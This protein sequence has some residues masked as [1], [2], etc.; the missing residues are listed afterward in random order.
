MSDFNCFE[1]GFTFEFISIKFVSNT[2]KKV[3]LVVFW[4]D[5][6]NLLLIKLSQ[7]SSDL[8]FANK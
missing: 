4:N 5:K 3:S 6:S 7:F 2:P 1:D 8:Y